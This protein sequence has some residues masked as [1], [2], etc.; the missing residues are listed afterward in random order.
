LTP[1]TY[2]DIQYGADRGIATITLD[3]PEKLN[4]LRVQTYD[5]LLQALREAGADETVGVVVVRGAGRAFCAGGDIEMAQSVLTSEAAGRTHF[6]ERM[7]GVSDVIVGLGKPV[8]FSI[9]GACVGGGAEM[10]LFADF[11]LTDETAYFLF[12]GTKIGGGNWWGAPQLLPLMVGLRRAQDILYLS[13]RIDAKQ[14]AEIGLVTRVVPAGAL[15]EATSEVCERILDLSEEGVRL[16]KAALRPTMQLLL[17][18]Q[19]AAAELNVAAI[20]RPDLHA[21]FDAFLTGRAMSWRA[22][23]QGADGDGGAS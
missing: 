8:V 10:A 9:H 18:S 13:T 21:A 2:Q 12:N 11:V 17:S 15:E 7:I 16:T 5:E 23:R 14:A 22:L 4:A 20:G 19:A 3:R 6:F 1:A